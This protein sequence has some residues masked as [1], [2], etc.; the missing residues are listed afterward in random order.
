MPNEPTNLKICYL[1]CYIAG[2][3]VCAYM[4]Y[5]Y[6]MLSINALKIGADYEGGGYKMAGIETSKSI[7]Y[8]T[9]QIP[10]FILDP[11]VS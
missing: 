6:A 8:D 2:F 3:A 4:G 9:C 5:M 10:E 1:V 7:A 11:S